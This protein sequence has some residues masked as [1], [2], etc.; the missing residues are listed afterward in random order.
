MRRTDL[1]QPA[2]EPP[3]L[4]V[5]GAVEALTETIDK[6]FGPTDGYTLMGVAISNASP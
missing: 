6:K 2:Y 4:V 3:R 1:G 5:L